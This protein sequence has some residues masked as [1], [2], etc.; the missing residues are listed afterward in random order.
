MKDYT[1]QLKDER[2]LLLRDRI[3]A[4]DNNHCQLCGSPNNLQVHHKYYINGAAAWEYPEKALITI[5]DMCHKSQHLADSENIIKQR[6][7]NFT[8]EYLYNFTKTIMELSPMLII[9]FNALPKELKAEALWYFLGVLN[10]H[11]F[12]G[13]GLDIF[14]SLTRAPR[15]SKEGW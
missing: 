12:T 3:L 8:N 2:W 6:L 1:E 7:S 5:C 14:D 9:K 13:N 10:A 4:R 15:F 11:Q